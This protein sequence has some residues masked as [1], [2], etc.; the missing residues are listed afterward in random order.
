MDVITA[1]TLGLVEMKKILVSIMEKPREEKEPLVQR[2]L[3]DISAIRSELE[4][5]MKL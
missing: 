4:I 1:R 2:I 3:T 5:L